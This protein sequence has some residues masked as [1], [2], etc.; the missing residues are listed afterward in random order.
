MIQYILFDLDNTLYSARYGLE[1][2]VN[3]RIRHFLASFLGVTTEEAWRQRSERIPEFGTTL[4]WIITEKGFTDIESYFAFVH[5]EDETDTLPP[6]PALRDFLQS[7]PVPKAILT[8]SPREHADRVLGKLGLSGI[9]SH[10]FDIRGNGLRGKPRPGSY[11]RSFEV[12][13]ARPGEVLF[14]DDS[15]SYVEGCRALGSTAV[16]FDEYDAW[17]GYPHPRI[18]DLRELERYIRETPAPGRAANSSLPL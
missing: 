8:N 10:I 3:R 16:L 1:T 12:L 15:P 11:L 14:V 18:R 17:P 7:L 6:D 13:G 4:E 9:F 5:P 2:Q